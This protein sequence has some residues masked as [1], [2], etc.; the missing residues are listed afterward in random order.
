MNDHMIQLA[1]LKLGKAVEGEGRASKTEVRRALEWADGR[2]IFID[3]R[4]TEISSILE[5][6]AAAVLRSGVRILMIDPFNFIS[7][8]ETKDGDNGQNGFRKLLVGLKG[9]ALEH[10][11][12]VWLVAHPTKLQRDGHGKVPIPTGYDISG[13]AHFFNVADQGITLSRDPDK[14]FVSRL[15]V[16]KVRNKRLGANGACEMH[17][18]HEDGSFDTIK[19]W[20]QNSTDWDLPDL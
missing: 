11:V 12:A 1:S 3:E 5:R 7:V 4:D 15:T 6:A 16:W 20:G 17:F 18:N 19:D 10:D 2:F 14:P 8:D 13:S 9:F